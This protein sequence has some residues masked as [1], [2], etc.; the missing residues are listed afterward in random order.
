VPVIR[1]EDG[2]TLV[3]LLVG[4]SISL[5]SM[6]LVATIV[7]AATQNQ[8]RVAKRVDANSRI[9]PVLTRIVDELHSACVAPRIVPVKGAADPAGGS[10]ATRLTFLTLSGSDP[11]PLPQKHVILLSGGT[12]SE[13][14]STSTSG[15][16]PNWTFGPQGVSR[17]LLTGV[18]AP[19]NVMFKYY[20]FQNGV[21]DLNAPLGVPL[22]DANA[23]FVVYV[24]ITLTAAPAS[25]TSTPDPNASITLSDAVDLRLQPAS[26]VASQDNLPCT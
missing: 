17:P 5:L 12:V 6:G 3:E 14:V 9:R 13:S 25:R 4:L 2:F 19:G 8:Q 21:L 10:N 11:T 24:S 15:T 7:T 23:P 16:S 26:Q 18:S 22:S 20:R 1:N